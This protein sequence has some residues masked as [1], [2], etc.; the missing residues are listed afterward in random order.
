MTQTLFVDKS[1]G[2]FSDPLL[3]YGLAVVVGDVLKRT[4]EHGQPSVRLSDHGAYYRLDCTPA[5]DDARLAGLPSPY[6]PAVVIRTAKN[7]AKLPVDL[8][9]QT[10]VDYE[11]ERDKRNTFFEI[12][13]NLPKEARVALARGED[14]L[15][16]AVLRGQEP[17]E[18]WDVFR[19]INPSALIGYNKLMTH[20]WAVQEALPDVLVLLRDLFAQ[21]PNDLPAAVAAWKKLDKAHGWGINAGTTAAQIYNPSQGKG[22][23]RTKADKLSMGNVKGFWLVE[24]LKAV[25]F[26]HA[27]LT[28]QLRGVKDRKTYVLAPA[29]IDLEVSGKIMHAFQGRMARAETAIRSDVLASIRYT[30][31][32][33]DFT[34]QR[35]G[36]SLK[37]RLFRH[38]QPSRVVSG[39]YSAFYKDL[40][41]ATAT[42]NLS[43]IRLPGW[44]RVEEDADVASA[45]DVLAEHESIVRQFDESHSDDYDLLLRY[46]DFLSGND[47]RPF[48]EF[49]TAYSG[50]LISRKERRGGYVPQFTTP[51]LRRLIMNSQ[52]GPRLS[53]ILETPGFQNIA[54]AIRQATVTAQYRKQQGN[55]KYDVRYGLGQ[56]LARKAAYPQEFIAELADFLAKY[57]AENAQVMENRPGPYRRSIRTSDIDDIVALID[58]FGDSRLICN[59]LVAYGYARVPRADDAEE[60][61]TG[62]SNQ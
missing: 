26:Y 21:T 39:F 12:R 49:T 23:N 51:N 29:E 14:H 61:S 40:G 22:Q 38:R 6:V 36:A 52:E 15:A 30:Q 8:P 50:Y 33:L 10:V 3:A 53:K 34:R 55:R 32:M 24:W 62:E 1:T 2:T 27:A 17:H 4:E 46:R 35:E 60:E 25:G 57:N 44:V 7:A 18:H 42:M 19:A 5:L 54:Y 58:E 56:Q 48:F 37:A 20:W 41:N 28:K 31:A 43:F 16:L 11:V 59:L 13:K 9:P 47:L 45:L